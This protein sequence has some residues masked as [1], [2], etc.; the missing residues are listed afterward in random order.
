MSSNSTSFTLLQPEITRFS[1]KPILVQKSS[2]T[3]Y[4]PPGSRS[5]QGLYPG[6]RSNL[7]SNMLQQQ[8]QLHNGPVSPHLMTHLQQHRLHHPVQ[9]SAGYLSGFQSHLFNPHLSSSLAINSA[10]HFV[11]NQ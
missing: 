6:D 4:P 2:F 9:Q 10:L 8:L 3:S 1:S 11:H 7:L 5:Q